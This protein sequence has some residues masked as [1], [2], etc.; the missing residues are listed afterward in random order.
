MKRN[1]E[2]SFLNVRENSI[3]AE[4]GQLLLFCEFLIMFTQQVSLYFGISLRH[5]YNERFQIQSRR[6]SP[7]AV[8]LWLILHKSATAP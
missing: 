8:S 7:Y 1:E 5:W 2:L 3:G 6:V 4:F